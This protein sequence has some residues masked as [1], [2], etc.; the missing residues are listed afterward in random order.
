[1]FVVCLVLFVVVIMCMC[2]RRC[3]Y[4]VDLVVEA[5]IEA[6]ARTFDEAGDGFLTHAALEQVAADAGQLLSLDGLEAEVLVS[7]RR[8]RLSVV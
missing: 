4:D 1:M 7:G 6:A 8:W 3:C 2:V 5:K